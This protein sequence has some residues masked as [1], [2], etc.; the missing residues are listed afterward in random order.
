MARTNSLDFSCNYEKIISKSL[1]GFY[2]LSYR[3]CRPDSYRKTTEF[4]A[5]GIS[6]KLGMQCWSIHILAKQHF[7]VTNL[8][9]KTSILSDFL[10][11]FL[12][13]FSTKVEK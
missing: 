11:Y 4:R 7:Y 10:S 2:L 13:I 3:H 5:T 1:E 9:K 6:N 8:V 12:E